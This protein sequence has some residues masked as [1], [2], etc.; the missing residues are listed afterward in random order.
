MQH[1]LNI[2]RKP[3]QGS[4]FIR[5]FTAYNYRHK[6]S[7]TGW[8]D[9]ASC[10]VAVAPDEAEQFLDQHTGNRV[11]VYVDNPAEPIWEGFINRMTFA[12]GGYSY[13][14]SLDEMVNRAS[15]VYT[16][17]ATSNP[18]STAVANNTDSQAVYGIK[19]GKVELGFQ[20]SAGTGVA[21]LRD[22]ILNQRAW[23]QKSIAQGSGAGLVTLEMLGFWHTLGWDIAEGAVFGSI[24]NSAINTLITSDTLPVVQNG[25]TFFD[26][27]DFTDIAANAL[28]L[29]RN[30]LRGQTIKDIFTE[31][32]EAGD[33]TNAYSIGITPTGFA[34]GTRRLYYRAANTAVEY[35]ARRADGLRVRNLYGQ[36]VPPWNVRPDRGVR[37]SDML[38][39]WNGLGDDPRESYIATID[40]DANQQRVTWTG[41]DN[42]TAEGVFQLNQYNRLHGRRFGAT[43]RVT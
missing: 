41:A 24:G 5:R 21:G 37:I 12:G 29:T 22:T 18:S 31:L 3:K 33:A 6:I 1:T 36:I 23:P 28:T 20:Y 43:R 42:I 19:A 15:V 11:A 17:N 30:R 34:S 13:T 4:G 8:F 38:P 26:N 35:T 27:A 25:T 10:D 7:A 2:Y 16:V 40:Y 14:V 39:G 32:A 9:T